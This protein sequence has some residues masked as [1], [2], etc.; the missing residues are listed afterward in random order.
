[1]E[2]M[3]LIGALAMVLAGCGGGSDP[4]PEPSQPVQS[5]RNCRYEFV[6]AGLTPSLWTYRCSIVGKCDNSDPCAALLV[7]DATCIE[8]QTTCIACPAGQLVC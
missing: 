7:P 6:H 2:R 3:I 1:M 4:S 8:G 5:Y